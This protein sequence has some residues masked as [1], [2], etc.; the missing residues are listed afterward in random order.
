MAFVGD[1]PAVT[2]LNADNLASGTV[3]TARL[4]TGT[5]SSS[6]FLRG[7]QSWQSIASGGDYVMTTF[8][9]PGTWTKPAGLKAV[10]VTVVGGGGNGGAIPTNQNGGAG[11]GGGGGASIRYI[12]AP[13]IP[14]PVTV[15]RGAAGGT[16]SFGPFA[17]ATGGSAGATF[18]GPLPSTFGGNG[19]SGSSGN[20]NTVGAPGNPGTTFP[21]YGY[22]GQGGPSILGGGGR[23]VVAN[24]Q[25]VAGIAGTLYGGGGGGTAA[26][27][28]GDPS[29]PTSAASGGAGAAGIVIVEEFY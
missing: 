28:P 3:G 18:T 14:G 7:D 24:F 1:G 20:V 22:G 27:W 19:G 12:P 23:S 21:G 29:G 17:S 16:S 13:T 5:A 26:R 4:G 11:G 9:A 10:K 2:N 6:T 15:T 25:S 8:T